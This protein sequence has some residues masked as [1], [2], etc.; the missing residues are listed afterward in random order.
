MALAAQG[1]SA[2]DTTLVPLTFSVPE[3][4]AFT[5]L[6]I[7]PAKVSRASSARDVG[8]ALLNGTDS[9]GR[10]L[11]GVALGATLWTLIPN[12]KIGLDAYQRRPA[13]YALA[14]TQLSLGTARATGDTA[15][16][17]LALGLRTTLV[18][19]SDPMT[20]RTFVRALTAALDTCLARLQGPSLALPSAPPGTPAPGGGD[21]A[22]LEC[23]ARAN[24]RLRAEWFRAHWNAPALSWGVGA[25]WR[26]PRSELSGLDPLGASTWLTGALPLGASGQMLAQLQYDRRNARDDGD[27]TSL[28][29]YGVRAVRGTKQYNLFAELAGTRRFETAAG[30]SRSNAQW[31]GGIEL[32][33]LPDYWLSTGVGKRYTAQGEPDRM[34]VLA[35]MRWGISSKARLNTLSTRSR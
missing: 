2:S 24:R 30:I 29:T 9:T 23:A 17:D 27:A 20:S 6:G 35:N 31:S 32:E 14:N 19:R 3:A 34:V 18:D 11:T 13:A 5:F 10:V 4:P 8:A 15:S 12:V 16:T 33:L 22:V 1:G 21:D 26:L 28:L 7:S 25:G